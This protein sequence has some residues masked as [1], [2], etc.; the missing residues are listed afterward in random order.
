MQAMGEQQLQSGSR[1]RMETMWSVATKFVESLLVGRC[2]FIRGPYLI[3]KARISAGTGKERVQRSLG[4]GR[5]ADGL[6]DGAGGRWERPAEQGPGLAVP[7]KLNDFGFL[8]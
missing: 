5:E 3:H 4:R 6:F 7:R 1:S 8:E 2:S